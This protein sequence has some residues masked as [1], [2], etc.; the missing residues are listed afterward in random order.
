MIYRLRLLSGPQCLIIPSWAF[1][2]SDHTASA[3][4]LVNNFVSWDDAKCK[5]VEFLKKCRLILPLFQRG[6]PIGHARVMFYDCYNPMPVSSITDE[7]Q[8]WKNTVS[9]STGLPDALS[10]IIISD[11]G[12]L[13]DSRFLQDTASLK[14]IDSLPENS[15]QFSSTVDDFNA[16]TAIIMDPDWSPREKPEFK[17]KLASA[18]AF[19]NVVHGLDTSG[20]NATVLPSTVQIG[21]ECVI[22]TLIRVI[23]YWLT[24]L[25]IPFQDCRPLCKD[26]IGRRILAELI[27]LS[28]GISLTP[29]CDDD[30]LDLAKANLSPD[31]PVTLDLTKPELPSSLTIGGSGTTPLV[32]PDAKRTSNTPPSHYVI[33]STP[34][35]SI[36]APTSDYVPREDIKGYR[37]F[38]S[39]TYTNKGKGQVFPARQVLLC[40]KGHVISLFVCVVLQLVERRFFFVQLTQEGFSLVSATGWSGKR[41]TFNYVGM[42]LDKKPVEWELPIYNQESFNAF[43]N[44]LPDPSWKHISPT[45]TSGSDYVSETD[46]RVVRRS[47]RKITAPKRLSFASHKVL[48]YVGVNLIYQ[49]LI[50][51]YLPEMCQVS[52]RLS[53]RRSKIPSQRR[54]QIPS[55]KASQLPSQRVSQVIQV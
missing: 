21:L 2:L 13:C 37:V 47:K 45:M 30:T 6:H 7:Q 34:A 26:Q 22:I 11:Y 24:P 14:I 50:R 41:G 33:E 3:I 5:D 23:G 39:C 9:E 51:R 48:I 44:A 36:L 29:S 25:E 49:H 31:A 32:S 38:E 8:Q 4:S 28:E 15:N 19:F 42:S 17:D 55:Q 40:M 1:N 20:I 27:L 16:V 46:D 10:A 43:L 52:Q 12:G 18:R 35:I 54:S 53:Q